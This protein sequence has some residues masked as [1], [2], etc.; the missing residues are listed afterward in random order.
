M[1]SVEARLTTD[2]P[3]RYLQQFCRHAAAMS[4]GPSL[5]H[6]NL[7]HTPE[8]SVLSAQAEWSDTRGVV[9]FT[10]SGRCTLTT[11][12]GVLIV[13]IDAADANSLRL[14]ERVVSDDFARFGQRDGLQISWRECT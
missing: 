5:S 2:R 11:G 9:I 8:P 12:A 10:P 6:R 7:T 3:S 14:I 13:R 4:D 1:P